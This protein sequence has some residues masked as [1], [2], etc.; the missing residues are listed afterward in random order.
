[1]FGPMLFPYVSEVGPVL[2]AYAGPG[3]IGIGASVE[4]AFEQP[5]ALGGRL[6]PSPACAFRPFPH[7][8]CARERAP[9][10]RGLQC[11]FWSKVAARLRVVG[12]DA[13]EL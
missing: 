10:R 2:G 5:R 13:S 12:V 11:R 8:L 4:S 7:L 3:M 6:G 1:M 9:G